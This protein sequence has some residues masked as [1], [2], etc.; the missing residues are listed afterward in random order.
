MDSLYEVKA[1]YTNDNRA[2]HIVMNRRLITEELNRLV[3]VDV[4][5]KETCCYQYPA[6]D[7]S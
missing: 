6:S 7:P 4:V 1:K 3:Y 5:E 2:V